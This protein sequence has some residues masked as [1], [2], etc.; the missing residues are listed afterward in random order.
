MYGLDEDQETW[1]TDRPAL[2]S[3]TT[4]RDDS[5]LRIQY[6]NAVTEQRRQNFY[7]IRY[8]LVYLML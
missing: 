4:P 1:Q 3:E 6:A 5:D 8:F 7:A 2:S